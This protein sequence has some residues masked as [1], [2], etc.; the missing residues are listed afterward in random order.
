MIEAQADLVARQTAR[1]AELEQDRGA[2][3]ARIAALESQALRMA[4]LLERL[5][6]AQTLAAGR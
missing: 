3:N 2:Q 1:L 6:G 5:D 4:A